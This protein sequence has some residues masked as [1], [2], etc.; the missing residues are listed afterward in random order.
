D[1]MQWVVL[2]PEQRAQVAGAELAQL[3]LV[4]HPADLRVGRPDL[5]RDRAQ[6]GQR[7][8]AADV[9]DLLAPSQQSFVRELIQPPDA[10]QHLQHGGLPIEQFEQHL[11]LVLAYDDDRFGFHDPSPERFSRSRTPRRSALPPAS[12]GKLGTTSTRS[13]RS[14]PSGA[15]SFRRSF[16]ASSESGPSTT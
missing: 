2:Q 5:D 4:E 16:G 3:V 13:G 8:E 1:R 7:V 6:F 12:N 15:S 10:V 9:V 14:A 11:R